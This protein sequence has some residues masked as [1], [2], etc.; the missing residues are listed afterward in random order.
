MTL[1]AD[2]SVSYAHLHKAALYKEVVRF[3]SRHPSLLRHLFTC[4]K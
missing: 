1:A 3:G 4:H 2:V